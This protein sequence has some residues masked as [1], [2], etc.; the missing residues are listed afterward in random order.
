VSAVSTAA[1]VAEE[2]GWPILRTERT[3]GKLA[4]FLA[5]FSA[6]MATWCFAIGGFVAY[7]LKAVP[8]TFAIV[9]GALI[10]T[11]MIVLATLPMSVKYGIDA[12]VA[13]RPQLGTRGSYVSIF[14]I[15]AS[16]MGWSILL[17]IYKGNAIA[18]MLVTYAHMPER[19]SHLAASVI[20][21]LAVCLVLSLIW[22]G[23]EYIRS[24]GPV[25]A[26][27]VALMSL[28]ILLRLVDVV[29]LSGVVHAPAVFPY[30]N[31]SGNWTS[32]LEVMIAT[33]LSWW[34]YTG[35]IVRTSTS[36]KAAM[37]PV[38]GG[39]GLGGGLG[40][41]VGLY[42]GVAVKDSGGDPTSFLLSQGGA[43]TGIVMVCF[44]LVANVGTAMMGVYAASVAVRQL[45]KAESLSWRATIVLVS[46]PA[47]VIVALFADSV[48]SFFAKF[49][50]F[51]GVAFAPIC[52]I[53][54]VDWFVLRRGRYD[55]RSLYVFDRTSKYHYLGGFNVV[56]F[57]A[58]A[59]GIATYIYLLDPVT[60]VY[61]APF[62]YTS[63][64]F[65]AAVVG[66]LTYWLG[67]KLVLV[68][69]R[70]GG[71]AAERREVLVTEPA[72]QSAVATSVEPSV[73]SS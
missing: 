48:D 24:R 7:Y 25:I 3:F 57:V 40:T 56:G 55:V 35:S 66:G 9:A 31:M 64:S 8:G 54:I 5:C 13:S 19:Y 68:P 28:V 52:G 4:I 50:A 72:P 70:A 29:G 61:R 43:V 44:L 67:A 42:T 51:L 65:P 41:L 17:F 2:N 58:F 1:E 23:P 11:L 45:P 60:Y 32:S 20:G 21:V 6:S 38:I 22:K 49:L 47:M 53:Q 71:Y 18:D 10:G 14:L 62:Q 73:E 69:R 27:L 46:I 26:I 30:P 59:A 12:V 39:F 63:A 37:W 16:A 15:Y 34:A 36:T 33:N